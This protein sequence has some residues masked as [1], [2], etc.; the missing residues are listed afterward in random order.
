MF[1]LTINAKEYDATSGK[2]GFSGEHAGVPFSGVFTSWN[3]SVVLPPESSA[4]IT[5]EFD[6]SSATTGDSMY[7]TTLPEYDWF[8]TEDFPTGTFES[9]YIQ[10][11]ENGSYFV[12][13]NL[14]IKGVSKPVEF[15]LSRTE[16]A[17][18]STFIINRMDYNIGVE[19]DPDAEWVSEDIEMTLTLE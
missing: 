1:S 14:T 16:N 8:N 10:D 11:R 18:T 3:A 12:S 2:V 7:D 5:A 15:V 9:S 19:S 13:G 4:G 17:L 6:L